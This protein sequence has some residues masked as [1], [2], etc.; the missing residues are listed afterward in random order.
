MIYLKSPNLRTPNV[1]ELIIHIKGKD[2]TLTLGD[3]IPGP[4][5]CCKQIKIEDKKEEI[6]WT[7]EL[8]S[9]ETLCGLIDKILKGEI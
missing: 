8:T 1:Y 7:R 9:G 2:I 5:I 4:M 3:G 6:F